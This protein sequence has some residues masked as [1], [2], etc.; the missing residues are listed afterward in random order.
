M[1][2]T[3]LINKHKKRLLPI[4]KCPFHGIVIIAMKRFLFIKK[5]YLHFNRRLT[6]R[7]LPKFLFNLVNKTEN[8]EKGITFKG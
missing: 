8:F 5:I 7:L 2:K 3:T 6:K 1:N 4:I